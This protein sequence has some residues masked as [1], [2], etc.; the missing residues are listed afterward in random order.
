MAHLSKHQELQGHDI[1]A[2]PR[3][4][5]KTGRAT[6]RVW[7]KGLRPMTSTTIDRARWG[8][9]TAVPGGYPV[10]QTLSLG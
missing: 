1:Q 4:Q 8:Q 7:I 3:I 9:H 2:D 6:T 10:L 5:G